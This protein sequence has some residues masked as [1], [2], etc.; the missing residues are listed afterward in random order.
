MNLTINQLVVWLIVGLLV[1][2][3][4]GM[5]IRSKKGAFG[6]WPNRGVGLAGAICGG[7]V[8]QRFG[9]QLGLADVNIS[10]EDL[11]A[12]SSGAALFV[13]LVWL[14]RRRRSKS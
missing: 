3:L 4:A 1:G 12:A 11:V 10:S 6:S 2:S 5:M 9:I 8:F 14:V 13:A 7:Y